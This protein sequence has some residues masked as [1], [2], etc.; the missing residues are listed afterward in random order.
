MNRV[1]KLKYLKAKRIDDFSKGKPYFEQ[2]KKHLSY[3]DM[4]REANNIKLPI[5]NPD[6]GF[7]DYEKEQ[8]KRAVEKRRSPSPPRSRKYDYERRKREE[9]FERYER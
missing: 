9:E 6:L 2:D 7:F 8:T 3:A 4:F 5:W 1:D